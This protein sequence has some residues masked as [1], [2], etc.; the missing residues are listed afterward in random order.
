MEKQ[1][2]KYIFSK[3]T[4]NYVNLNEYLKKKFGHRKLEDIQSALKNLHKQNKIEIHDEN[5]F[6]LNKQSLDDCKLKAIITDS[7]KNDIYNA[8]SRYLANAALIIS[9]FAIGIS[10]TTLL[11]KLI[12]Q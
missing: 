9:I 12:C 7:G 5:H 1:I 4:Y 3:N 11:L 8:R 10:G 2:L 6:N